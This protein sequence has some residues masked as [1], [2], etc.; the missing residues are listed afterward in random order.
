MKILKITL[1]QHTPLIHF[2]HYEK[3]ATLR[4][5]EVKPKLDRYIIKRFGNKDYNVGVDKVRFRGWIIKDGDAPALKYKLKIYPVSS[6]EIWD[7][8]EPKKKDSTGQFERNKDNLVK[9]KP[10]PAF[11]ANM[12]ANYEDK[13]SY[14]KFSFAPN[15]VVL[16][17]IFPNGMEELFDYIN[18]KDLISEFFFTN[19][20][21]MRSSKGFG[22]FYPDESDGLY[23]NYTSKYNFTLHIN[24]LSEK[25]FKNLFGMI[26]LFYRSLRSGI[27]EMDYKTGE[28][29]FYFK[30]LIRSFCQK[31]YGADWEKK[32]IQ[33]ALLTVNDEQKY[34]DIKDVLGFS[35]SEEWKGDLYNDENIRKKIAVF[36]SNR[37]CWRSPTEKE[38]N[39]LPARMPSPILIKPIYFYDKR[40]KIYVFKIYLR[41]VSA[42]TGL[43][44]FLEYKKIAVNTNK[45]KE[46]IIDLP[47]V[48]FKVSE[49]LNYVQTID[50]ECYVPS[51]YADDENKT[52]KKLK[53]IY[54]DFKINNLDIL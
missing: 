25:G 40:K 2:Q 18:N 37:N 4:A 47:E 48:T 26:D 15:G 22:S 24:Q 41:I 1:K 34:L 49:F 32:K 54:K 5:S 21:G 16:Q 17:M 10:Y 38:K 42:S 52:Y 29:T 6:C 33:N 36:D 7:I 45:E 44:E 31:R 46:L 30:S 51:E 35:T 50:I 13:Y 9:L 11:F 39:A 14:K 8:N 19:N 43:R 28:V 53:D 20:F 3:G 23:Q 27:K 12:N